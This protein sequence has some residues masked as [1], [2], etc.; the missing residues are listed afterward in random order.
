MQEGITL[1]KTYKE[2]SN[3]IN[4]LHRFVMDEQDDNL[5][6]MVSSVKQHIDGKKPTLYFLNKHIT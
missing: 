5:L 6:Q 1:I 3:K 2:A 4:N